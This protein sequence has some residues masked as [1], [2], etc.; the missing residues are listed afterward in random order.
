MAFHSVSFDRVTRRSNSCLLTGRD[1]ISVKFRLIVEAREGSTEL[2]PSFR[3]P[4]VNYYVRDVDASVRFYTELFGFNETFRTPETG[5]PEHVEVRL[6]GLVLGLAS[7]EAARRV[8]GLDVASGPP[9]AE[10]VLWT[11]NVDQV[12][13]E[14]VSQGVTVLR[15]PHDF[16]GRL[17]AAWI[18]DPDGNPVEIVYEYA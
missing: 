5:T 10:V 14:L 8:H 4:Q 1:G 12:F 3:D 16:L 11:D 2:T 15:E 6:G 18:A 13:E 17:R 9:R 7:I